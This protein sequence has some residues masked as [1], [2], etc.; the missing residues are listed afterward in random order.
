MAPLSLEQRHDLLCERH[1]ILLA[2]Y[3][4]RGALIEELKHEIIKLTHGQPDTKI[5]STTI[6]WSGKHE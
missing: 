4:A 1:H 6:D 5:T 3:A 2:D